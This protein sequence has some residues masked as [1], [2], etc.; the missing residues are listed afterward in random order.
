[1]SNLSVVFKD[2]VYTHTHTHEE[3]TTVAAGNRVPGIP[4]QGSNDPDVHCPGNWPGS[5]P[6]DV[7][8]VH[9]GYVITI[10]SDLFFLFQFKRE[11]GLGRDSD[12]TAIWVLPSTRNCLKRTAH[13]FL[14]N[15]LYAIQNK[16]VANQT[17]TNRHQKK[18][19]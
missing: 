16:N 17:Q 11:N 8:T 15:V 18:K 7:F 1:M 19:Q 13:R 10:Q 14:P 3:A 12:P 2:P 4:I 6:R 9:C 5:H